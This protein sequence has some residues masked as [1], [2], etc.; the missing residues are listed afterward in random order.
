M[1]LWLSTAKVDI[2]A[3]ILSIVPCWL[4]ELESCS[5]PL[6]KQKVP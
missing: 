3:L 1:T 6:K 2:S 5:N 4:I